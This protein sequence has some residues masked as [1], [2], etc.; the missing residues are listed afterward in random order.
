MTG[1]NVVEI[2]EEIGEVIGVLEEVVGGH[3]LPTIVED[4]HVAKTP[5]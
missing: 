2:G 3:V 4:D 1:E 5:R